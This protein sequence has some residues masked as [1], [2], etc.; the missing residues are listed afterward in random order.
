MIEF[1]YFG[2][3]GAVLDRPVLDCQVVWPAA[4]DFTLTWAPDES[5]FG[6]RIPPP[7]ESPNPPPG[8]FTAIQER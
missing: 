7:S 1:C 2:V 5:Q 8:L 3:A 4:F 6:G